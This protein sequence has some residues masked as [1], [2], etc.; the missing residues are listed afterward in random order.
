MSAP[1]NDRLNFSMAVEIGRSPPNAAGARTRARLLEAAAACFAERGYR[2]T[3]V[4]DITARAGCNV[5]AVSYHFDGKQ[6][7]YTAVFDQRF[8]AL[9]ERRVGALEALPSAAGTTLE[10]VL[11]TFAAVFLEPLRDGER[12]RETMRLFLRDMVESHLPPGRFY[13]RM[14]RPTL[15]ALAQALARACPGLTG[16]DAELC[17]HSLVSQLVHVMHLERLRPEVGAGV[18]FSLDET[19]G[20]VVAVTAA[21]VRDRL[22]QAS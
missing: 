21:G 8:D 1:S 13:E 22:E 17:A 12:G 19:V 9:I 2:G 15:A 14:V 3:S 7:L 5:A 4:R 20:H 16:R 10:H 18:G 11:E 6:D